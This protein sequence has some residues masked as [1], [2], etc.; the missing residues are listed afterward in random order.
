MHELELSAARAAWK[1]SGATVRKAPEVMDDGVRYIQFYE[2]E[3]KTR[4]GWDQ[5]RNAAKTLADHLP[6]TEDYGLFE[7]H[8]L[9]LGLCWEPIK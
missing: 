2:E 9:S 3:P 8:L 4:A 1:A 5:F 7:V 6:D